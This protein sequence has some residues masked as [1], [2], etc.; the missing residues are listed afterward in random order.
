MNVIKNTRTYVMTDFSKAGERAELSG[1]EK[2][3]RE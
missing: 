3:Y 2:I 1:C